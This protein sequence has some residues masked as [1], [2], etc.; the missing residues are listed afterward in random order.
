M[1]HIEDHLNH[2]VHYVDATDPKSREA[3]LS[4]G[5]PQAAIDFIYK[6]QMKTTK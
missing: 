4:R 6:E 2:T 3:H 1:K 5:L